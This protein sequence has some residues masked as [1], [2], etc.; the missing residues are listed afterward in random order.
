MCKKD[1]SLILQIAIEEKIL[2]KTGNVYTFSHPI[3]QEFFA[4]MYIYSDLEKNCKLN[5]M[6]PFNDETMNLEI[7]PHLY[8]LVTNKDEFIYHNKS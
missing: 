8:N 2:S 6:L 1:I 3:L 4:A 5:K 7:A